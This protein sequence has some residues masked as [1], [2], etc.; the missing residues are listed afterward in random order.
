MGLFSNGLS[1]LLSSD[2]EDSSDNGEIHAGLELT[3]LGVEFRPF[4]FFES[5]GELMGHVFS[6]TASTMTPAYQVIYYSV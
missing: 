1:S 5:N 3:V 4:I 2:G 6:G